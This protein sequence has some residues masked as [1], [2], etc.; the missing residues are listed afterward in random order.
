MNT[1]TLTIFGV[2]IVL[3]V[4][5]VSQNMIGPIIALGLAFLVPPMLGILT[6]YMIGAG[7]TLQRKRSPIF[8]WTYFTLFTVLGAII[9][10][11]GLT[12]TPSPEVTP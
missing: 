4:V 11:I 3:L 12:A 6:G 10:F 7:T 2:L 1:F 8:F 9:L 5:L